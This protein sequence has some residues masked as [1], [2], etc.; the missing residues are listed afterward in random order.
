MPATEPVDRFLAASVA[1]N[2]RWAHESDR[3][4]ATQPARDAFER[5]FLDEVDPDRVLDVVERN[6]RAANA[7]TAYFHSL[8]LKSARARRQSGGA[9]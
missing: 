1:A 3:T 5:R 6:R 9:A 8:A 7:R 4:A 2:S